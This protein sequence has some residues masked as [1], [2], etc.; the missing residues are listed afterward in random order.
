LF[1]LNDLVNIIETSISN[2]PDFFV[3]ILS[4]KNPYTNIV[5]N[6]TALYN[7][8]FQCKQHSNTLSTLFHLYFLA[9]FDNKVFA[10]ENE[11]YI[12]DFAIKKY[13]FN[14]PKCSL[15]SKIL[16]MLKKNAYTR[17]LYIHANFPKDILVDIMRPF[18]YY[19]YVADYGVEGTEK[20]KIYKKTLYYKLKKF[21]EYNTKF[22]RIFYKPIFKGKREI[23]YNSR[24]I[25]FHLIDIGDLN[26]LPDIR[27]RNSFSNIIY[28][29]ST[30][31]D[32]YSFN[33]EYQSD[34]E[35]EEEEIPEEEPD[36]QEP[37]EEQEPR[38]PIP[39]PYYFYF[40]QDTITHNLPLDTDPD[41]DVDEND[42]VS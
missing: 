34:E 19:R 20:I 17:K 18:L 9:N 10:L 2:A 24:H 37:E 36:E 29:Y 15:H 42:S 16:S 35:Q 4:P 40:P 27:E 28:V 6:K 32:H 3:E 14:T 8:Y 41:I 5:F 13:V 23:T 25:P 26:L 30:R 7:I 39:L 21:Y 38:D 31:N 33:H 12:R 11:P 1:V 22:G